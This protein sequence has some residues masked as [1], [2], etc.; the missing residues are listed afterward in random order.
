[1]PYEYLFDPSKDGPKNKGDSYDRL[2]AA[3][4]WAENRIAAW[5][6]VHRNHAAITHG[7]AKE[8][9]TTISS[10][11]VQAMPGE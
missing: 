9:P 6:F 7:T 11:A 5:V 3:Y 4:C 1:M 2:F 10:E 8:F